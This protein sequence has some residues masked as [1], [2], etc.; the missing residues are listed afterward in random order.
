MPGQPLHVVRQTVQADS[1]QGLDITENE[2]IRA[3]EEAQVETQQ[4]RQGFMTTAEMSRALDWTYWRVKA[5][6]HDLRDQGRLETRKVQYRDISGR[7][8]RVPAY[9]LRS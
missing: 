1:A 8:T 2:L 4:D 9:R 7:V 3:L 6:L 5:Q